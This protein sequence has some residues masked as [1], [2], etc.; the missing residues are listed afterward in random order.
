MEAG[1]KLGHFEIIEPLGAGGMGEVY[2]ARDTTLDRHV[3]IKVLPEDLATDSALLAR[4]EREARLLAALNHPNIAVIHGL[5]EAGGVRFLVLELIAGESLAE[6]LSRG[7][8]PTRR[9]LELAGQIAEA[10]EA[11]HDRGIIHRDIKPANVQLT[12]DGRAKVLDFGIAKGNRSYEGLDRTTQAT[13]LTT[14]GTL[15]GT[16]PYMSP[17]HIRGEE[18]DKR[19]DIW[20]FGCVAYEMLAGK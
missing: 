10:I 4:F 17:E 16:A 18:A 3:A 12:P 9:A 13:E 15:L 2:R 1:S 20:A 5:E 7:A 8:L 14:A 19:G 6:V 11:A